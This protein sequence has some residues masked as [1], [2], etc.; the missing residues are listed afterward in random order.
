MN[1]CR[2][3][4]NNCYC[5]LFRTG[6]YYGYALWGFEGKNGVWVFSSFIDDATGFLGLPRLSLMTGLLS[7]C[8]EKQFICSQSFS[9][10]NANLKAAF[11]FILSLPIGRFH[12]AMSLA[13]QHRKV[14][15][16]SFVVTHKDGLYDPL[17]A[18]RDRIGR[19]REEM[20]GNVTRKTRCVL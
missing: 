11:H 17:A 19:E 10:D 18:R 4:L 6:Y 12:Q 13:K 15:I 2:L 14:A 5:W 20:G 7:L 3:V 8:I 1:I 9:G 16:L